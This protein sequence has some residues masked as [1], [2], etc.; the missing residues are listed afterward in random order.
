M[1]KLEIQF[2]QSEDV[3]KAFKEANIVNCPF[4]MHLKLAEVY[5]EFNKIQVSLLL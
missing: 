2:S 4:K 3:E 5:D 1:L